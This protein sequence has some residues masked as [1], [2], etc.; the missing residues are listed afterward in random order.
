MPHLSLR[1]Q[2]MRGPGQG[3]LCPHDLSDEKGGKQ[4]WGSSTLPRIEGE[5]PAPQDRI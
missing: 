4:G 2:G 5:G 1:T 3:P